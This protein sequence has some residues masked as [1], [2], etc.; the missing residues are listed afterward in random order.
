MHLTFEPRF[1]ASLFSVFYKNKFNYLKLVFLFIYL[2]LFFY[3][4]LVLQL[5]QWIDF[6]W[7]YFTLLRKTMCNAI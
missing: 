4:W 1:S 7:M 6:V 3:Y 2:Y 5:F